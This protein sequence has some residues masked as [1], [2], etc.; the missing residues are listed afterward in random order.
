MKTHTQ[1]MQLE[2]QQVN[3]DV[4]SLP[5]FVSRFTSLLFRFCCCYII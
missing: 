5:A 2:I 4:S 1:I 3:I